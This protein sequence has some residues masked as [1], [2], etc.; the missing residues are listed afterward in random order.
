MVR[1]ALAVLVLVAVTALPQFH[2]G[3]PAWAVGS[4]PGSLIESLPR[5]LT[6]TETKK[7]ESHL[8]RV[9]GNK[10][11]RLA[12]QPPEAEV[13]IGHRFIGVV[14][15]EEQDGQRAFYF[16]MAI[17][18]KDLEEDEPASSKR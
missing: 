14:Y 6:S 8:R 11:I 2:P 7:I 16:E 17:S 12:P 9:L 4:L 3:A 15:P 5:P 13:F 18:D 1:V 10:E